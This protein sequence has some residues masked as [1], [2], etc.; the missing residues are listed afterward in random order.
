M[1]SCNKAFT[2]LKIIGLKWHTGENLV[3]VSRW[4]Q[5]SKQYGDKHSA[6]KMEQVGLFCLKDPL[7]TEMLL[8]IYIRL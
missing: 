5:I 6:H 7:I 4:A 3:N 1:Q 8:Y 2:A